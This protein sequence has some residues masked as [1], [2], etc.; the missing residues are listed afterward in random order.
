MNYRKKFSDIYCEPKMRTLKIVQTTLGGLECFVIHYG[1]TAK[2][3]TNCSKYIEAPI[4]V[5]SRIIFLSEN[6]TVSYASL[7]KVIDGFNC[8]LLRDC[9]SGLKELLEWFIGFVLQ[10]WPFNDLVIVSCV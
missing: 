10:N 7:K 2:F 1:L 3:W 9:S 5:E 4:S 8:Y 6:T